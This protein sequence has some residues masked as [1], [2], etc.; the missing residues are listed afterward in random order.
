VWLLD[1]AGAAGFAICPNP[2]SAKFP[3]GSHTLGG[4]TYDDARVQWK[5]PTQWAI[6][7]AGGI[8]NILDKDP[9]VCLSCSLNGYDASNYDLPGRF[10]YVEASVKF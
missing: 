2:A 4:T 5:L 6:T 8:N 3:D 10:Y 9:P 7:V 1:S